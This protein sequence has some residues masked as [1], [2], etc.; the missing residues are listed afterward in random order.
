MNI[1][2]KLQLLNKIQLQRICDKF[3]VKYKK[4]DSK[5]DL[6]S[7]LLYPLV[8]KKYRMNREQFETLPIDVQRKIQMEFLREDIP[9][10][11]FVNIRGMR[12][13]RVIQ[14]L[15]RNG[16]LGR[17]LKRVVA[18]S[19]SRNRGKTNRAPCRGIGLRDEV[20]HRST[21]AGTRLS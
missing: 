5:K 21:P 16:Q 4:K 17:I 1:I 3:K 14:D 18:R 13:R 9:Q 6:I 19:Q 10:E 20:E 11:V 2:K 15:I 7:A 12:I 8:H